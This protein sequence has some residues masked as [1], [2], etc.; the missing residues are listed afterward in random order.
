M[1]DTIAVSVKNVSKKFRLFGSPKDRLREAL[2]PFKKKYHRE[3]WAL[4]D[5]NLEVPKGMTLGIVGRNG[6][7]KSTLLQIICS[8][9]QPTFGAVV[10]KG[11]VSALLELGTG[12]NPEFTGRENVLLNGALMGFSREEMED[13]LPVIKAFADIGEFVDQPVKTYSSG[14]F[15]RLAFAAAINVDPDILIV[16]EALAVG[17]AK[18]QNKCYRKFNEFQQQG[19]TIVFVTHNT[20]AVIRHCDKAILLDYGRIVKI[21]SPNA[22]VNLYMDVLLGDS[23]IPKIVRSL[24]NY[25]IVGLHGA[26]YAVP[27]KLGKVDLTRPESLDLLGI[28][29]VEAIE[30]IESLVSSDTEVTDSRPSVLLRE[31]SELEKFFENIPDVDNCINRKGYN[32]NEYRQ[33]DNRARIVDYLLVCENKI[34]PVEIKTHDKIDIY[35]KAKFYG[36]VKFPVYG[37]AIKTL[38]GIRVWGTN[39]FLDSVYIPS[40][41][42]S[43]MAIFKFSVKM[44][45]AKGDFFVTLAVAEYVNNEYIFIDHR[46]DLIH[47]LVTEDRE[48]FHGFVEMESQSQLIS[49]KKIS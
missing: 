23:G 7:G 11:R 45:L 20:E 22:V 27:L 3:F 33:G 4:K 41:E 37:I 40:A 34:D 46:T 24:A 17:D 1:E 21:D 30:D 9:L 31:S 49:R 26:Y 39:T 13:R 29:K 32:K 19:K 42:K 15:V 48:G 8:V 6:S 18:F 25:N 28:V 35:I 47:I 5:I 12:F 14:M 10:V 43:E 38:D 16:D 2:H 44:S 36:A